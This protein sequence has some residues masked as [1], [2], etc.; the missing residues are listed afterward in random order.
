[1]SYFNNQQIEVC[2]MLYMFYIFSSISC[3]LESI[4]RQC[5]H[6]LDKLVPNERKGKR[7]RQT[8]TDRVKNVATNWKSVR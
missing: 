3:H 7:K 6:F 2:S 8:W 5:V 1:M 4:Y